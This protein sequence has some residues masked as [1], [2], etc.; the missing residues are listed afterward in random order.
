MAL[1]LFAFNCVKTI[2]NDRSEFQHF[3][4]PLTLA[5]LILKFGKIREVQRMLSYLCAM[6]SSLL[7]REY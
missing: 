1:T 5:Y 2:L 4:S 3:F 7:L 6:I